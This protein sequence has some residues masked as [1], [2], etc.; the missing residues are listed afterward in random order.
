MSTPNKQT[1]VVVIGLGAAGGTAV[2]P[3]CEAGL[4]VVGI[5]AGGS[6]A[7]RDFPADEIRT[8][9][10]GPSGSSTST[11]VTPGGVERTART[12]QC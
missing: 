4:D 6:Y 9:T 11:T 12:R 8:S 2:M 1:D 3:L 10:P 5:E 7:P